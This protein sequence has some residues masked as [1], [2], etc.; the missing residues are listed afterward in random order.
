MGAGGSRLW[1][2]EWAWLRR[3]ER[4]EAPGGVSVALGWQ[5]VKTGLP[6]VGEAVGAMGELARMPA[7]RGQGVGLAGSPRGR[8]EAGEVCWVGDEARTGWKP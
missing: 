3:V 4:G 7:G 1:G 5:L 2:K 6:Y 8:T